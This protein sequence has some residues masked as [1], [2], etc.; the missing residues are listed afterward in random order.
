VKVLSAMADNLTS[1][2]SAKSMVPEI[3]YG[4]ETD[5]YGLRSLPNFAAGNKA[6]TSEKMWLY[7]GCL[8]GGINV[9]LSSP[10]L[11]HMI[12]FSEIR[13]GTDIRTSLEGITGQVPD[14]SVTRT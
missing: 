11:R 10:S 1:I 3:G 13:V 9:G 12:T 4:K 2:G 8:H 14:Q 7:P 6:F 5:L